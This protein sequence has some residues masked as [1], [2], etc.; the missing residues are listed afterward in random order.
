MV[1][2]VD[3]CFIVV[4]APVL[5][6]A[7]LFVEGANDFGRLHLFDVVGNVFIALGHDHFVSEELQVI[8]L[9]VENARDEVSA[10]RFEVLGEDVDL[11]FFIVFQTFV[12]KIQ[13]LC[14]Q[15]VH[16]FVEEVAK[17]DLFNVITVKVGIVFVHFN[18]VIIV[19]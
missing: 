17:D 10:S 16:L 13:H 12:Q 15:E 11:I 7:L 1:D 6:D 2:A 19:L 8:V 18:Q 5:E 9:I 4:L 14:I 3:A